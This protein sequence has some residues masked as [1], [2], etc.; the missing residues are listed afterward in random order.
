MVILNDQK[1]VVIWCLTGNGKYTFKSCYRFMIQM[2]TDI[3][4]SLCGKQNASAC[5]G[6][7]VVNLEGGYSH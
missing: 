5:Q 3:H 4:I 1:D 6:F 7:H 2:W